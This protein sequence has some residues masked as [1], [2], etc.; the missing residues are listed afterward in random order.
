MIFVMFALFI[1]I[2]FI[3]KMT[4]TKT[5]K[6][7]LKLYFQNEFAFFSSINWKATNRNFIEEKNRI[8]R[9]ISSEKR[10][11]F[12]IKAVT[13]VSTINNPYVNTSDFFIC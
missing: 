9:I 11:A 10:S 12:E 3:K 1:L 2:Y 7:R 5:P 8:K 13:K 6:T 4:K